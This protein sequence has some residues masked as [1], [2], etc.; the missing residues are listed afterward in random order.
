MNNV[1]YN[2]FYN[3]GSFMAGLKD[4]N[5][6]SQ[7]SAHLLCSGGAQAPSIFFRGPFQLQG[8]LFRSNFNPKNHH[9]SDDFPVIFWYIHIMLVH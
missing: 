1:I 8:G 5:K 4:C 3:T 6:G 2:I 7:T 9:F